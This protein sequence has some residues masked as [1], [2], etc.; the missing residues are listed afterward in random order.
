[1]AYGNLKA[2]NLIFADSNNNNV[3]TVLPL[4]NVAGKAPLASPTFTGTVTTDD[5]S[6]HGSIVLEGSTE[7]ANETTIAVT[8]PTADRTIT[9][10]DASGTVA[11]TASPTFTGTVTLGSN[12]ELKEN[13]GGSDNHALIENTS[14]G[15]DIYI[16]GPEIYIQDNQQGNNEW[17]HCTPNGG[18]EL[19]HGGIQRLA[20]TNIAVDVTG[21]LTVSEGANLGPTSALQITIPSDGA[22]GYHTIFTNNS[23]GDF[24]LRGEAISIQDSGNS[25]EDWINCVDGAGVELHH[26]GTKKLETTASGVTIS[27]NLIVDGTTTE[28]NST[29][30]TVDDKNIELG[31]GTG[32]AITGQSATLA[33]NTNDVTVA[34][35]VG[36]LPGA[37][38]TNLGGSGA[39]GSA[40]PFVKSITSSTVFTVGDGAGN[41]L[42]HTTAGAVTFDVGPASDLTADG[43]GIT[44]KG[45]TDKTILWTDSTDSWDFNQDIKTSG[46]VT[47]S[48][49]DL[50]KIPQESD[51][52]NLATDHVLVANDAG[53][54]LVFQ[55][56]ADY[57]A[58]S[59]GTKVTVNDSVFSAGDAVTIVNNSAYTL[60]IEKGTASVYWTSDGTDA[61]RTLAARG[62][63]TILFLSSSNSY[64]SGAGLS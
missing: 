60:F 19:Y 13:I 50:R 61:S 33:L 39:F 38:L 12:F 35:T 22:G 15:S 14:A 59:A 44:L 18:V 49:G 21:I 54:H 24:A 46:K 31:K 40:T 32:S 62:M 36:Y 2:D 3:D 47:D 5:V 26:A 30:L 1:M 45:S 25:N 52:A 16:R 17:I 27:G 63:A 58:G 9:L 28:I 55:P 6:I 23:S 4:E 20:T 51:R 56:T 57:V 48:K 41:V 64:I 42:N 29:T 7:D 37:A 10:P 11:L 34:S 43:G 53:Q 8:D